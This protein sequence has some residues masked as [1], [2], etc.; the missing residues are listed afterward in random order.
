VAAFAFTAS[1]NASIASTPDRSFVT[2]GEVWAVARAG[3]TI[4]LGGVFSEV[5]PRTGPWARIDVATGKVIQEASE[6]SGGGAF[7]SASVGDGAGGWYIGGDFTRVGGVARS[8]LAHIRADGTLD[9]T[10]NPA[11]NE[12]VFALARAGG[13]VYAGG[14]FTSIGGQMRSHIAALDAN[15]NATA[16]NPGAGGPGAVQALAVSGSILYAGG[17]FTSIAGQPAGYVAALNAATGAFIWSGGANASVRALAP[18]GPT[19]YIGGD[20]SMVGAQ[21]RT[22]IAALNTATGAPISWNPNPS[23]GSGEDPTKINALVASGSTVYAAGRFDSIGGQPRKNLAALDMAGNATAWNPSP[24][25]VA[26]AVAV[27]GATVY[28]GGAFRTVAGQP[29]RNIAAIDGGTGAV[30]SWDPDANREVATLAVLGSVVYAGGSFNS[31]GGVKRA[32]LAALDAGTGEATGWNPDPNFSVY[33]LKASGSTLYVGGQFTMM[34]AQPRGHLA[35]F[36]LATGNLTGWNPNASNSIFALAVSGGTLYAGGLFATMGGQPRTNIAAVD[37]VSGS[38]R[39]WTPNAD[40]QVLDLAV[41]GSTVYAGGL[42]GTIGGQTRTGI[43]ALNDTNGAA[44]AWNPGANGYVS[45]IALSGSTVYVGGSFSSI[46]GQTRQRIAALGAGTGTATGWNPGLDGASGGRV[47][48][49]A[50]SGTTVYAGGFFTKIGGSNRKNVGAVDASTGAATGWAPEATG[51]VYSLAP[52]PDGSVYA[53]GPFNT[54]DAAAQGGF[55]SFSEPP[56]NNS[57]PELGAASAHVGTALGCATGSWSGSTPQRYGFVWLRDG[58]PI[59]GAA[60]A[61]YTPTLSDAGHSLACRVTARNLGGSA[62]AQSLAIAV[63]PGPLAVTGPAQRIGV[64]R[65]T[66]TG[67]VNPRG[68]ATSFYFELGRTT[69]YGAKT[70]PRDIGAGTSATSVAND[71]ARLRSG[72][73]Y[74]YRLVA[75]S[76]SGASAGADQTFR[77]GFQ[78]VVPKVKGKTLKAAKK[79]IKRSH[80]RVG[81][82]RFAYSARVPK[83]RVI[84]QKPKPRM[85]LREGAKVTVVVS[86][87]RR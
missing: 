6:V 55:A 68:E 82:V 58:A 75:A 13:T 16:W 19:L 83:G 44:T 50:V 51:A 24:D 38:L 31:L 47:D 33:A 86:R 37:A 32:G 4:Y 73:L 65:A 41:S 54:F 14:L 78:C 59:E 39:G 64:L 62:S 28:A 25:G 18:A 81:K 63:P 12:R 74:H 84:A 87:G 1:V 29:R 49:L 45:A 11:P 60:A 48:T 71:L 15:G 9:P 8:N 76:A 10:F 67:T 34:G 42:F 53:G 40:N 17:N 23:P 5:G 30:T 72:T 3:D 27:S 43:A 7:V 57:P 2:D 21:P 61:S 79:A 77:T 70:Q 22:A 20:F 26:R 46:G 56:V 36:D 52:F 66:L 69:N 80:C 85:R 35:S